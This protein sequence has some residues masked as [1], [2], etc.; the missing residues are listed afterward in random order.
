[1]QDPSTPELDYL[2]TI[3]PDEPFE[4]GSVV[5]V[6]VY[7]TDL[8]VP[9]VLDTTYQFG[10]GLEKPVAVIRYPSVKALL[11]SIMQLDGRKSYDPQGLSLTFKWSFTQ[12]P[13][14]SLVNPAQTDPPQPEPYP[15]VALR[16]GNTAVKFIPDLLGLYAVELIVNNGFQDSDPANAL[17]DI[18]RTQVPC[19]E[20]IIPDA[21]F[22]WSFLSDFWNLVPDKDYFSSIWSAMMQLSGVELIKLWSNDYNKSLSSIQSAVHRRWQ[23]FDL[24]TDLLAESQRVIIGGTDDGTLGKTGVLEPQVLEQVIGTGSAVEGETWNNTLTFVE[25][26]VVVRG[27]VELYQALGSL[28]DPVGRDDGLG[29]IT[30][31]GPYSV[32][33]S[34]DYSSGAITVVESG[35]VWGSGQP[36][37]VR[38][39]S[40]SQY[41]NEF[42]LDSTVR[43]IVK[44]I[45]EGQASEHES[46]TLV[47]G[48]PAGSSVV[49]GSFSL[50]NNSNG[51]W[52]AADDTLGNIYGGDKA[53]GTITTVAVSDLVDAE[54]F[55]LDDGNGLV[56]FEFDTVGDGVAPGHTA[57]DVT[58][59][60]G[61]AD[62][63]RDQ[64]IAAVTAAPG[65]EISAAS[66]GAATVS[67]LNDNDGSSGNKAAVDGVSN[68]GFEIE[69]MSGGYAVSGTIDY[70]TW[71]VSFTEDGPV[72]ALGDVIRAQFDVTPYL[73]ELSKLNQ[74]SNAQG[75]VLVVNGVGYTI[76][77]VYSIDID[78][79][80]PPPVTTMRNIVIVD[81]NA[82]PGGLTNA[83]WRVPHLLHTPAL[84]LEDFGVS[85]GDILVFQVIRRDTNLSAELR[86][87]VVGVDGDRLGFEFT[88]TPLNPGDSTIDVEAFRTL[89]QELKLVPGG[90][91]DN[92]IT[93]AA[94]TLISWIPTGV[95][96]SSRPFT[97]YRIVFKAKEIIHNSKIR[98]SSKYLSIPALQESMYNPPVILRENLNY[99]LGDGSI[100]FVDGTF[101]LETP[102]PEVLWAECSAVDNS[103]VIEGNFGRFVDISPDDVVETR[104]P[105]LSAVRGLW[106]AM[107]NGPTLANV[108]LGLQIL[109][110]LPYSEEKCRIVERTDNFS[111][112][113]GTGLLLGRLL[114]DFL[115]DDNRPT[116]MRGMYFY[117]MVVGIETNPA[118]GNPYDTGDIVERWAPLSKGVEVTDY[119]KD[120]TWWLR[121]LAGAE[122]LKFF[123]FS[124]VINGDVFNLKD[125]ELAVRFLNNIKPAYTKFIGK[126]FKQ[127]IDTP[128]DEE[129]AE[130]V[131]YLASS[132]DDA[133]WLESGY[134]SPG[135]PIG[136]QFYDNVGGLTPTHRLDQLNNQGGHPWVMGSHPFALRT[137]GLLRDVYLYW[138]GGGTILKA[139]CS[140]WMGTSG[141]TPIAVADRI[142][143]RVD[144]TT[145]YPV[146][147]GDVLVILKGQPGT[148]ETY[149][150]FYEILSVDS[151]TEVTLRSLTSHADPQTYNRPLVTFAEVSAAGP[152]RGYIARR[153]LG[154]IL[155]GTDLVADGS[156][157]VTSATAKF[158]TN[159]IGVD[160]HV[161]LESVG[162]EYRI[163][164]YDEANGV[165]VTET[166]LR[167]VDMDGVAAAIPAGTG[168]QFRIINPRMVPTVI[169]RA[170]SVYEGGIMKL[171]VMDLGDWIV[172]P[173]SPERPLDVFT[174]GMTVNGKVLI[175]NSENPANDGL[176]DVLT[177]L[178]SGCVEIDNP[179]V[180]SD[181]S[182]TAEVILFHRMYSGFGGTPELLPN[183]SF[184]VSVE[185]PP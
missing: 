84:N 63:V 50:W 57:V 155:H 75:R 108:R 136:I 120:P 30:G 86:A 101:D 185:T 9:L 144:G 133:R 143:P 32:S 106:Y 43:R 178:G 34:I 71:E 44:D 61:D 103:A 140:G 135:S 145:D 33:G 138:T 174:P 36:V 80:G 52:V 175:R 10:V 173:P 47:L 127:L 146:R 7:C 122:I 151:D 128:L 42:F 124:A 139:S 141:G 111:T 168:I 6:H 38:F 102:S 97:P 69:G 159:G 93:A 160:H 65:F 82:I 81:E 5:N 123:V 169:P 131:E 35:V 176:F 58:N 21:K 104:M 59:P 157:V 117:P 152:L 114:V 46:Y 105:Y 40:D 76:D 2:I 147:E 28:S 79:P 60:L 78:D 20:G 17:L 27:S 161:I 54:T 39:K 55:G 113:A 74:R 16:P 130:F 171:K 154:S 167:L 126:V 132:A 153:L 96:V 11:G 70:D 149:D 83:T 18:G 77:R 109:L 158:L 150:S 24:R 13:S 184:E 62:Y 85:T 31:F 29:N 89:V 156:D 148:G 4:V 172:G 134:R 179:G 107:T 116:G 56:T 165:H 22:L 98:V 66:G 53:A 67:L 64:I 100:Q 121:P 112:E 12:V 164:S 181:A 170:Q 51:S 14:G 88:T 90:A 125:T 73:F 72:W 1:V 25:N 19:G 180:T 162:T 99:L 166:Q 110:G 115:G 45:A 183:D 142:K 119:I 118:T 48:T 91:S 163:Q 68:P 26:G 182:A 37:V 41:T 23:K 92:Q 87:Q 49:P 3:K 95:N 8:G 177:Y 94:N 15:F 129:D 137:P